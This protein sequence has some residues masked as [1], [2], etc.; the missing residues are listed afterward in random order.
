MNTSYA[1]EEASL[2]EISDFHNEEGELSIL[3]LRWLSSP[4]EAEALLGVSL[5]TPREMTDLQRT[6]T[7]SVYN[8]VMRFTLLEYEGDIHLEFSDNRLVSIILALEVDDDSLFN[9]F[10]ALENRLVDQLGLP[11]ETVSGF[12][13]DAAV[14]FRDIDYEMRQWQSPAREDGSFASLSLMRTYSHVELGFAL[15]IVQ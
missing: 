12:S 4:Q 10:E 15:F 3:N 2:L 11:D 8:A 13:D 1:E 14:F 6:D 7:W 9:V 5:G